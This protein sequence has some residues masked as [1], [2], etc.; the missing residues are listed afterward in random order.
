M[1]ILIVDD[2]PG[3]RK[4]LSIYLQDA[5]YEVYTADDGFMGSR[6]VDNI[7]PDI[8]LTDIKM[9]GTSGLDLLKFIKAQDYD[10]EVIMITGHG[11]FKLA[12]ESLKMDAIDFITKPIDDDILDIALKRATDRLNATRTIKKYT[13]NLETLVKEKTQKLAASEQKYVRLFNESPSFITTQD[14]SF[15]IIESNDIFKIHFEAEPGMKCYEVYKKLDH[16]CPNCPVAKS[17]E[18]GKSHTAEM[19]VTLKNG[20]VRNIFIQTSPM[21]D[22]DGKVHQVMEM[23]TDITVIR[24]LQDHLASLGLHIASVSHGIKGVLTGLDGGSYIVKS[25][26]K[27]KDIPQ[28]EEGWGIVKEKI[29]KVRQIVLDILFH[30]KDRKLNIKQFSAIKFVN[31]LASTMKT[32]MEKSAIEFKTQLPETDFMISIDKGILYTAFLGILENSLDA[33]ESV[34]HKKKNI[35]ITF[36]VKKEEDLVIFSIYDNGRG[37]SEQNQG[38]IFSLFYS[39][40]GDKGTGLGLFIAEKS[41]QKH[42]G[43]I[44]VDS[45][46]GHYT[47]FTISIPI[48]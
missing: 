36:G 28:I 47:N 22:S 33:C 8:V 45:R 12:M 42:Q 4:V 15:T 3:I 41:I 19:D 29:S 26:L 13:Q 20:S 11:D 5:G 48:L 17:F 21:A 32:G 10:T 14:K 43:H 1:K 35:A 30:S 38:N 31:E 37:L 34:K 2:E 40:K 9:P 7:K 18:N 25:G 6:M 27:K 24:R 44:K 16:P 23:S 39:E 46:E